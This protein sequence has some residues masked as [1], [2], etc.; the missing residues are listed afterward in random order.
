MLF[1]NRKTKEFK[2]EADVFATYVFYASPCKFDRKE[3]HLCK[4]CNVFCRFSYLFQNF[5]MLYF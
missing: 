1:I 2:I 4:I 5:D 3:R